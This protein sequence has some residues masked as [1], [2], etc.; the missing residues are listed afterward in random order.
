MAVAHHALHED[1]PPTGEPTAPTPP[2]ADVS[3]QP[4]R[5]GIWPAGTSD[6]WYSGMEAFVQ[7]ILADGGA[8]VQRCDESSGSMALH[9]PAWAMDVAHGVVHDG[10][11]GAHGRSATS[12]ASEHSLSAGESFNGAKGDQNHVWF[13]PLVVVAVLRCCVVGDG[14]RLFASGALGLVRQLDQPLDLLCGGLWDCGLAADQTSPHQAGCLNVAS[15]QE[16]RKLHLPTLPKDLLPFQTK[17][18]NQLL[19]FSIPSHGRMNPRDCKS[20]CVESG[21]VANR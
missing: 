9:G 11:R 17:V 3:T 7:G 2:R 13:A 16:E 5:R 18:V 8:R 12:L 10:G 6:A 15:S 19:K 20:A 21:D 1:A 4:L 14:F